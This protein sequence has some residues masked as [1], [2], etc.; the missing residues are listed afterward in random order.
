M[1]NDVKNGTINVIV[2]FK[3]DRLTRS[4]Y[5][6]EKL[7]KVVKEAN[8]DIDCLADDQLEEVGFI[9]NGDYEKVLRL[10][11][12]SDSKRYNDKTLRLGVI[13][14]DMESAILSRIDKI[15]ETSNELCHI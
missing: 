8:C 9:P 5:D 15:K 2:A 14:L 12:L 3:M 7:M 4:V 10:I 13:T 6:V 11:V 1:M